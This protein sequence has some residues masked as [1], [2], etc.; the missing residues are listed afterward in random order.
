MGAHPR[1]SLG[2][3]PSR[4]L[5]EEG[6]LFGGTVPEHLRER[7]TL[8]SI[9]MSVIHHDATDDLSHVAGVLR[10]EFGF[11]PSSLRLEDRVQVREAQGFRLEICKL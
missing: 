1:G 11:N 7:K 4:R 2:L 10:D 3:A 8:D 9:Q 5:A 6:G